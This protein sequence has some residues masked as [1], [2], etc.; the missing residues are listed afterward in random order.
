MVTFAVDDVTPATDPLPT[1]PLGELY[2]DAL[3]MGGDPVM[4]VIVPNGVHHSWTRPDAPM[5]AIARWSSHP[6]RSG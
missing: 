6:T 1:Q 2:A 5:R 3:V 4:R